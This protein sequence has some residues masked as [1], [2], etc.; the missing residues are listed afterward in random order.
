MLSP[1]VA[2]ASA[3]SFE[4]VSLFGTFVL[5]AGA[6]LSHALLVN[7]GH[8]MRLRL[9]SVRGRLPDSYGSCLRSLVCSYQADRDFKA[10]A[11]LLSVCQKLYQPPSWQAVAAA[12]ERMRQSG[13]KRPRDA[14]AVGIPW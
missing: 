6:P 14:L 2:P 12:R 13:R 1:A 5:P 11:A 3:A 4:P 10:R 8:A 7:G 9:H